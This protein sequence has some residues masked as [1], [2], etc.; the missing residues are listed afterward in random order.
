MAAIEVPDWYRTVALVG[1]DITGEP[2][3]VL[4]DSTGAIISIMKGEYAGTLKNVQV[5]S[6]GRMIMIPTDPADIW[7]N[8]IS[9]GN[10]EL[11]VRLGFP[12]GFDRRGQVFLFDTFEDGFTK[13]K[14]VGEGTNAAV[15][16]SSTRVKG[17][18]YSAKLTAGSDATRRAYLQ[19]FLPYPALGKIGI[20]ASF[21]V[22]PDTEYVRFNFV[23]YDG[24]TLHDARIRYDRANNK[25]QYYVSPGVYTDLISSVYLF[26]SDY[27]FHV[28]KLVVDFENDKYHRVLVDKWSW[29]TGGI[30]IYT[31]ASAGSIQAYGVID[32]FGA[33][34]VNPA[35]YV[36]NVVFT[37]NEPA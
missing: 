4:L 32:H 15:E 34:G 33:A 12:D 5:D 8:A 9:M 11:A 17:G 26:E 10:A 24:T 2:V 19:Y 29:T 28:M 36:D 27:S 3:V 1:V 7:G 37:Q 13:A 20:T 30:D 35:I 6:Q 21:T 22:D 18:R 14:P 16:I 31:V 25:I 23:L